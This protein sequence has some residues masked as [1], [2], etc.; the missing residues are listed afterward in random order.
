MKNTPPEGPN[1]LF[2]LSLIVLRIENRIGGK[3]INEESFP[4]IIKNSF[5]I[6]MCREKLEAGTGMIINILK[7]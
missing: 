3:Y 5:F 1:F 4:L 2:C 6:I 7:N